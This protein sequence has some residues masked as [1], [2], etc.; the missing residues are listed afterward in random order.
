MQNHVLYLLLGSNLGEKKKQL[1]QAMKLI[2]ERIGPVVKQSSVYE[3]E[4]WGFSSKNVFLNRALQIHTLLSPEEVLQKINEVEK[5]FGR[6]R[7]GKGYSSRFLDIDILF[8]DDLVLDQDELK[9]PHPLIQE[10]RFVLIPLDEIA[11]GL[12]HPALQKD[13]GQLLHDCS[14]LKDVTKI[15]D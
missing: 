11:H 1:D 3:T 5:L 15:E 12:I 2:A 6:E 7:K 8:Y 10:R 9:I 13:I 14:D 4:P